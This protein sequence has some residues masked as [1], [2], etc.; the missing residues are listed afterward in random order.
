[1]KEPNGGKMRLKIL[2]IILGVVI[3]AFGLV[4][5]FY[6]PY[7]EAA[8]GGIKGKPKQSPTISPSASIP[9]SPS[10]GSPSPSSP[11]PSSPSPTATLFSDDFSGNLSKWQIV[12]TGYGTVQIENGQLMMAPKASTQPSET[13]APLIVAG[14]TAWKDY[15]FNV[16]MNTVKQLRTGSAPNPWEVG[17]LVF[18]YVDSTHF[19][20]FVQKTNGIELG[21]VD[22]SGTGGQI[23]LYTA[24]TPKLVIGQYNDYQVT[25][26]G[27]NI[28]VAINGTQ[29]VNYTD[30]NNPYL[31]GKI[32]LYNEDAKTLNDNVVVTAN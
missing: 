26:K 19:Y 8:R 22:P 23:F 4:F 1:M 7:S 3:I 27:N 18:R 17:W 16:K 24:G 12:Y 5:Y 21:R 30:T 32:G 29:V 13:H 9:S 31:A 14:D 2:L 25:L 11:S 6:G 28:K 10:P 20:Y 15:I